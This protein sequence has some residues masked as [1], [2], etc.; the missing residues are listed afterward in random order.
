MK[1]LLFALLVIGGVVAAVAFV[2]KRRSEGSF[3]EWQSLA[4]TPEVTTGE[5]S[6]EVA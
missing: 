4:E 6:R 1:K 3:D 2:M 5:A